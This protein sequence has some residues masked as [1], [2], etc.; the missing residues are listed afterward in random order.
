MVKTEIDK[1][2]E[3]DKLIRELFPNAISMSLYIDSEDIE[4]TPKYKFI[5]GKSVKALSGKYVE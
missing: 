3:L 1:V 2:R 4:V 5:E